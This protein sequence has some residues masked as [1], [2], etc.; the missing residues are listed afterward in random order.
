MSQCEYAV[1]LSALN[2]EP[3]L[4]Y[5]PAT[6]DLHEIYIRNVD[7]HKKLMELLGSKRGGGYVIGAKMKL[8]D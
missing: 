6:E 3:K 8:P 7:F 4:V 2:Q 5:F 1:K